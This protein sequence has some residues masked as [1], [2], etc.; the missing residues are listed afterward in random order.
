MA[1]LDHVIAFG[2]DVEQQLAEIENRDA[3]LADLRK[4][5]DEGS[6]GIPR[7]S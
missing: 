5:V 1:P 6:C 3:L 7:R 2:Q 4:Q